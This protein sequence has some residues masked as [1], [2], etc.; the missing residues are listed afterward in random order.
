M[1]KIAPQPPRPT[2]PRRALKPD[3]PSAAA[4][5]RPAH[6][7]GETREGNLKPGAVTLAEMMAIT[8]EVREQL[9][10]KRGEPSPFESA[11]SQREE[12]LRN[13]EIRAQ[14][15]RAKGGVGNK[16]GAR[17]DAQKPPRSAQRP[18]ARPS[19]AQEL[20]QRAVMR[21]TSSFEGSSAPAERAT[22]SRPKLEAPNALERP[23]PPPAAW[24]PGRQ[25]ADAIG[26]LNQAQEPGVYFREQHQEGERGD[27]DEDPELAAAVEECIRLLF[28]VRGIHHV[29]PGID[30]AG[31][32]VIVV[33]VSRGFTQASMAAIPATVHRFKT[34]VALPFDLLPLRRDL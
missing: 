26:A 20:R 21:A 4:A 16:P 15:E 5:E 27:E 22:L 19:A 33:S 1:S 7:V 28:G 24:P 8:D 12:K 32:P 17:Q 3:S 18:G 14:N 34:L 10:G 2:A 25:P 6:D 9:Q 11:E 23:V 13:E 31:E 29:G 30:D